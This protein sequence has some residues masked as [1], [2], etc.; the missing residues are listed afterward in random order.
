MRY[1]FQF[2]TF[3]ERDKWVEE[4]PEKVISKMKRAPSLAVDVDESIAEEARQLDIL[5]YPD[6]EIQVIQPVQ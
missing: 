6:P 3:A 5:V 2:K 4:N 1:L